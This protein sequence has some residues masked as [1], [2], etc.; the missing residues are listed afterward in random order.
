[1]RI[2]LQRVS[3]ASVSVDDEIIGQ[4]GKGVLLFLGIT[5]GDSLQD[6]E[7]LVEKVLGMRIYEN[8]EGKAFDRNIVDIAGEI[9]IV[10]QFTLYARTDKGR[11]PDFGDA[12]KPDIADELYEQFVTKIREKSGLKVET[13]QFQAH[14]MVNL[15]NDGPVTLMIE[16]KKKD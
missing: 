6:V 1:M 16:S 3:E 4:I 5:H 8:E 13:G 11:R 7:Y 12:E 15:V 14:M 10:S 9:L 2:L